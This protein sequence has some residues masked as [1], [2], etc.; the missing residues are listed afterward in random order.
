MHKLL[1]QHGTNL[2]KV[3]LLDEE[4]DLETVKEMY[5]EELKIAEKEKHDWNQLHLKDVIDSVGA[6]MNQWQNE[7]ILRIL[8][9][10]LVP[11]FENND[12]ITPK[13]FMIRGTKLNV[14]G[15]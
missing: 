4:E 6:T 14:I 15:Y 5:G 1:L 7:A 8:E 9:V 13:V 2:L 11:A 12:V 3:G 10:G